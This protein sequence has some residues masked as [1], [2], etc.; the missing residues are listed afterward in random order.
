MSSILLGETS[1]GLKSFIP[2]IGASVGTPG[3]KKVLVCATALPNRQAI[4]NV[5][6]KEN[7]FAQSRRSGLILIELLQIHVKV[8]KL[9]LLYWLYNR[10]MC[11]TP[12]LLHDIHN[13]AWEF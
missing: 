13:I 12:H 7:I 9:D 1:S 5:L 6:A 10:I 3:E 2:A 8:T 4:V 11:P